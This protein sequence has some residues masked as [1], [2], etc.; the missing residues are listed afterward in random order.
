MSLKPYSRA[1]SWSQLFFFFSLHNEY[2]TAQGLSTMLCKIPRFWV[3]Q[4]KVLVSWSQIYLYLSLVLLLVSCVT[5]N[6][7]LYTLSLFPLLRHRNNNT[8]FLRWSWG[9]N[10]NTFVKGNEKIK[11]LVSS[12][13]ILSDNKD[14]VYLSYLFCSLGKLLMFLDFSFLFCVIQIM[15]I[16]KVQRV[17]RESIPKQTDKKSGVPEEE[18]GV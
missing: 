13:I 6:N 11:Y 2:L 4:Q 8:F 14:S 16:C 10:K 15:L 9:L 7:L 5:L 17:L 12:M 18:K 3:M 1:S